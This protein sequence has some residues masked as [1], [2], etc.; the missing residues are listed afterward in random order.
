MNF[1]NSVKQNYILAIIIFVGIFLRLYHLDFQSAWG[2]EVLVLK[3]SEPSLKFNEAY[4]IILLRDSTSFLH[5]FCIHYLSLIFGHTVFTARIISAIAGILSILYIYKLGNIMLNKRVGYI[6][7]ILLALNLFHIEY[8]QEARSYSLLVLFVIIAFYRLYIYVNNSSL[9]NALYLGIWMGLVTNA[10]PI[11]LLN[12][13]TIFIILFFVF[14]SQ[15]E[16][17][18]KIN[19]IKGS[20]IA[21]I[22]T[23]MLFSLIYPIVSAASKITSFWISEASFERIIQVFTELSG[24]SQI[25]LWASILALL[26]FTVVVVLSANRKKTRITENKLF[27]SYAVLFIWIFFEVGVVLVKSYIGVSI[28]LSRYLIAILPAMVLILAIGIDIIKNRF[29]KNSILVLLISFSIYN[30]FYI[31]RYYDTVTKSQFDNLADFITRKNVDNDKVVSRFGWVLSFYINGGNPE[32]VVV[33]N[34]L[35]NFI[36]A[37]KNKSIPIESFWYFDGNSAEYL[38]SSENQIFLEENFKIKE[39]KKRFDCWTKHY[40]LKNQQKSEPELFNGEMKLAFKDFKPLHTDD[41]GNMLI[42]QNS[43]LKSSVIQLPKG[44]YIMVVKGNSFP[45]P[46]IQGQNAHL[47]IKINDNQ[48]VSL[49]LSEKADNAM[50]EINFKNNS[51]KIELVTKIV[52]LY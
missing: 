33:E 48:V 6:A 9:L 38:V 36:G 34:T 27:F 25:L 43:I 7:A 2:D 18:T 8:S 40:I 17:T 41:R 42:F 29:L 12:V 50:H 45:S 35:D 44:N 20:V 24:K 32:T 5:I 3:E 16:W 22:V 19:I 13:V 51:E 52:F 26:Y 28:L 49:Y 11:G 14:I 4:D 39:D 15:K 21:G 1:F 47:K 31:T 37:M 30:T 23:L 46:P 10:H